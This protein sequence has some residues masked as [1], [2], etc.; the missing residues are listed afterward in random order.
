MKYFK[1]MMCM[2]CITWASLAMAQGVT[3][4]NL[5]GVVVDPSDQPLPGA[6]I[7]GVHEPTGTRYSAVS[8]AD[9]RFDL[10]NVRVGGPYTITASMPGFKTQQ[11]NNLYLKLGDTQSLNFKMTVDAIEE[12]LVVV[13]ETNALINAGRQGSESSVS[14][15]SIEKLPTVNRTITDYTRTNPYFQDFDSDGGASTFS[16]AGRN[17]RYNS[18]LIDGAVN[19][20]LFGLTAS[21]TPGGQAEAPPVSLEAIQEIQLLVSPYDVRQGG[22][23]GGGVNAIT[24]SGTNDFSGSVFHY[25]KTDSQFGEFIGDD[26][27]PVELGDFEETQTGFSIGGPIVK[28]KIFFFASAESRRRDVPTGF[29]IRADNASGSGQNFGFFAEAQEFIEILNGYGYDPGGLNE[30]TRNTDNDTIFVRFDFNI[31]DAHQLTLRHNYVDAENLIL[32]PDA[33]AYNF[34]G[35]AQLFPNETNSTVLQ[36]NSSLGE[37]YNE[38]RVSYQTIKDRRTGQGQPFPWVEIENIDPNNV[39]PNDEFRGRIGDEFEAG[40]ERFSTANSLDQSIIEITN[41]LTF[42]R[43]AHTI[44]IGTHNE[45]F[46][47]DNLFIR[48]NFGAYQFDTL[49]D[50][51]NGWA[52]QYDYSFSA[53]DDPK[54]SAKFDA[55]QLG[56]YVGDQ[57]TV[58]PTLTVTMGLRVD[59]PL[60]PDEPTR[61]PVLDTFSW[62]RDNP[63][64]N[65]NAQLETGGLST[66][67]TPDGNMLWSPRVGFNWDITG[68]GTQQLRGG[69]GVFSGRTP[70][71][72]LS[73]Q[74]ANTGIEFTRIR[75]TIDGDASRD[76]HIPFNPDPN[77]QPEFIPDVDIDTN[78]ID[79]I[80]PDFKLPQVFRGNLAYDHDLGFWGIVASAE[81]IFSQN[82]NEILYQNLNIIP[83]RNADGSIATAFDGRPLWESQDNDLSDVIYLTNTS[84]GDSVSFN[85][86][87]ERPWRD[88]FQWFVSYLH[89]SSD[90]VNDG[91]S[92]QAFSNW[93]FVPNSGDPNNPETAASRFGIEDRFSASVAY[94]FKFA[95]NYTLTV[96]G[97]YNAQS[98]R[99]FSYIFNGDVN[100]DGQRS[101]D[102]LYVPATMDEVEWRGPR[103]M[104]TQEIWDTFS[105]FV[106]ADDGLNF[107]EIASRN[108]S[109][110][111]WRHQLDL[112]ASLKAKFNRYSVQAYVNLFNIANLLDDEDGLVEYVSFSTFQLIRYRGTNSEGKPIYQLNAT[113]LDNRFETDPLRS[114]WQGQFGLRFSF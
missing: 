59:I 109:R 26:G 70:Y 36:L 84:E 37:F 96:S 83:Q 75:A 46:D 101:N 3:T 85:V 67:N 23:S 82:M 100:G 78:E 79:V 18:I 42:F 77:N 61:N 54:Q 44:T 90:S 68:D 62:Y 89:N 7:N 72:W 105:E 45:L 69:A 64:E 32:N 24:K 102:L 30:V 17:N 92:S 76:N 55:Q 107:G 103:E 95:D 74:Y 86:K 57:W 88:G 93:R 60:F 52:R 10:R 106:N 108:N 43:G 21:G 1:S 98:G 49:E 29:E 12:T 73:N 99:P 71:V 58:N 94:D 51:R 39:F 31:G 8:R 22:F 28:D 27:D 65:P 63:I 80:D 5:T 4:A 50:F 114:R 33:F 56:F 66:T 16:V 87:L 81:V 9:G 112:S 47:F 19:N 20:D 53:T 2:L 14:Q 25:S 113:E 6:V 111:P 11:Q 34:P 110:A 97:F 15:E 38:F 48:E 40:T 35:N 41:D 104:S 91:T 13:A